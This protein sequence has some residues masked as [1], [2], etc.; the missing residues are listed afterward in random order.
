MP[1]DGSGGFLLSLLTES[2]AVR[3]LVGS[4]AAA[5]LALLLVRRDVVRH[6][7]A[8][9]VTVLAPVLVAAGAAV[10]VAREGGAYLPQLWVAGGGRGPAG[11]ILDLL[12]EW[13]AVSP[14]TGVDVLVG[15]YALI[16][17]V[18][19]GRRVAGARRLARLLAG[20][21]EPVG[22]GRIMPLLHR[23][24][25]GMGVAV[26]RLVL[27]PECPG[28][29]FTAGLRRPVL[30]LDPVLADRLDDREMEGLLA[31]E[32][33]HL[34][35]R[36]NHVG[37]AVGLFRDVVFFL[38]PVH[39]ALR[40]LRTEQEESADEL[41]SELT[42]RPVALASS[43]LKVWD[44]HREHGS[45]GPQ[46]A[47]AAVGAATATATPARD[48][49]TQ[50]VERL[51][52]AP[53]RALS[54]RRRRLEAALAVGLVLT[55]G[56]AAW[57]VPGWVSRELDA[58]SLSF[59]YLAPPPAGQVESPAF[60]TFRALTTADTTPRYRPGPAAPA[61]LAMRDPALCPCVESITQLRQGEAFQ[62]E[63]APPRMLW[64]AAG[65]DA[66]EI[67]NLGDG[68]RLRSRPLLALTDGGPQMGFFV[69]GRAPER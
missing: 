28:G 35:R 54:R 57:V 33:A 49:L 2:F 45:R 55:G 62:A 6:R 8:R 26:P 59:I 51:L 14:G 66:W 67:A 42:G 65:H 13:R 24:S 22:Y 37:L 16:A 48:A 50:R 40:W 68:A 64:R 1:L 12:G 58:Y 20:A 19:V 21:R 47:C 44:R 60:A 25:A 63:P 17:A 31:H 52:E 29:A 34:K 41:A 3:A 4:L 7:S 5:G 32:L 53:G 61:K 23:L 38:P 39:L 27:L 11:E 30:A 36:D 46:L 10:A 9:R 18:L 69:V 43:I 15:A 56:V